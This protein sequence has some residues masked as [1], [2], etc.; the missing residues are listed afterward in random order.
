M[1]LRDRFHGPYILADAFDRATAEAVL[2]GRRA[3]LVAFARP[4]RPIPIWLN[5]CAS[6]PR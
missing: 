6:V 5:G 3:D 4:F 2:S 1:Q